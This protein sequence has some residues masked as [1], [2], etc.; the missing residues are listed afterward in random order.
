[1]AHQNWNDIVLCTPDD[2]K[3]HVG[4]LA[5]LTS[6]ANP[7]EVYDTIKYRIDTSKDQLKR[8]VIIMLRPKFPTTVDQLMTMARDR[9]RTARSQYAQQ[10]GTLGDVSTAVSLWSDWFTPMTY[11]QWYAGQ[12]MEPGI[13]VTDSA[14]TNGTSGTYAG[15]AT[16]GNWLADV[17]HGIIYVNQ[18][19]T[20][21]SVTWVTFTPDMLINYID[22]PTVLHDGAV[23]AAV[24][25]TLEGYSLVAGM[26]QRVLDRCMQLL[27]YFRLSMQDTLN[28]CYQMLK[29]DVGNA[30]TVPPYFATAFNQGLGFA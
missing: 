8:D 21:G 22:D 30:G 5:T 28:K 24:V 10:M 25:A 29:V 4:D 18:S 9:W 16:N 12:G 14:P 20:A 17:T 3:Q 19:T 27:S 11:A 13:W 6:K 2:V 7:R 1:M 23:L 15:S 26:D